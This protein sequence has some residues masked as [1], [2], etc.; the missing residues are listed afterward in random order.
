ME[1]VTVV[2]DE[3]VSSQSV[4]TTSPPD[5]S[6]N[7]MD[8]DAMERGTSTPEPA[9]ANDDDDDNEDSNAIVSTASTTE[10]QKAKTTIKTTVLFPDGIR[11][12]V[13]TTIHPDGSK[14]ITE[15]M[16]SETA[17]EKE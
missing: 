10:S 11:K 2:A 6:P 1:P 13:T 12:S 15:T 9:A 14:T 16:E 5:G 7:T 8:T 4:T 17:Y 3:D